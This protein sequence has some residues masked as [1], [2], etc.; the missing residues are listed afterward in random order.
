MIKDPTKFITRGNINEV[1]EVGLLRASGAMSTLLHL[2]TGLYLPEV[3]SSSSWPETVRKEFLGHTHKFLANLTESV[4]EAQG[5]TVL[6][7][8]GEGLAARSPKEAGEDRDLTQRLESTIIHWTRQIK[9]VVNKQDNSDTGEQTG[10]LAEISFWRT[11]SLDLCGIRNQLDDP[12]VGTIVAVL[13]H[14]NSSYLPPFLQLKDLIQREAAAAEDNLKFLTCLEGP[15]QE[16]S[17]AHPQDIPKLLP[18]I[19]DCIRM[20][21]A[22]TQFYNTPERLTGLLRKLS[23]EIINRCSA[24]IQLDDV[25]S[26]NVMSVMETLKQSVAAGRQ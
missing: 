26:G 9:D 5:R 14:A 11:R 20:V 7:V 21:W 17:Q 8:P 1:V 24:T 18:R 19:L 6:Y 25:F 2:M 3:V 4:Y 16:L 13:T 10:P 23:N 15:C 22:I 12:Q